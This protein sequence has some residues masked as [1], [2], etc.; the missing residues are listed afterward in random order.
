MSKASKRTTKSNR[1]R[2]A[3]AKAKRQ[4]TRLNLN[5]AMRI[6]VTG[7]NKFREPGRFYKGLEAMRKARTVGDFRRRYKP[8]KSET[9]GSVL[10]VAVNTGFV[11]IK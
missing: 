1:G 5:D 9:A 11:T 2:N 6:R 8:V 7:E 3:K 10:R 4:V